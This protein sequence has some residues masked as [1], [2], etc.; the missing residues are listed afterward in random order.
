MNFV[1]KT[2]KIIV[3]P[4]WVVEKDS[5]ELGLRIFGVIVCH[6]YKWAD[7]LVVWDFGRYREMEKREFGEVIRNEEV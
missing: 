2:F 5:G 6:Y 1:L 3:R 4:T 7:A